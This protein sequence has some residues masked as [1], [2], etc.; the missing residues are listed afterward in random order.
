MGIPPEE[1][2]AVVEIQWPLVYPVFFFFAI[3]KKSKKKG[4]CVC[5]SLGK[6]LTTNLL[7][8]RLWTDKN[9][10]LNS[11]GAE[12]FAP[13]KKKNWALCVAWKS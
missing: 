11:L 1:D 9:L 8:V 2:F 5:V 6:S 13:A 12:N 7:V 4:L 10:C 3:K